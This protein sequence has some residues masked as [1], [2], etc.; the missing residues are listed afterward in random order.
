MQV[1]VVLG[2][3]SLLLAS[4]AAAQ[5]D[6]A[7]T[8][9]PGARAAA[10]AGN[11]LPFALSARSDTQRAFVATQGGYDSVREGALFR[12]AAQARI[13]GPLAVRAAVTYGE[14]EASFKPE[15]GLKVDALHQEDHGIDLAIAASYEPE[16]FNTTPAASLRLAL[17]RS[18]GAT[19]LLANVGYGASL[20][21][22]RHG[23]LRGGLLHTLLPQLQLGLDSRFRIDLERDDDEPAGEPEW[24]FSAG[25]AASLVLGP[26]VLSASGGPSALKLRFADAQVG[27]M[28]SVG[29]GAAF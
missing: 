3:L 18:L 22:E 13:V 29:V 9:V 2:V 1:Q 10:A 6:G 15:V 20:D 24:D 5:D 14:P 8:P 19:Q 4:A 17:G 11:F 26:V 21:G 27:V 7:E 23:E 25:P 16:G 28:G 12:A